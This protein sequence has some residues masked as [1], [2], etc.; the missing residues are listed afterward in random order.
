MDQNDFFKQLSF[1]N[2][3]QKN[4]PFS[5]LNVHVEYE[6]EGLGT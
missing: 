5:S 4:A 2:L 6:V 3:L 1:R